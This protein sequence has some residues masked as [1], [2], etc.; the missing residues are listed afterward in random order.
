MV[1]AKITPKKIVKT[2]LISAFTL[3]T[4]FM[5]RDVI[6]SLI[7]T[8]VPMGERMFYKLLAAI[9]ATILLILAIIIITKTDTEIDFI[10]KKISKKNN[11]KKRK[12]K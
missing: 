5:W 7:E 3:A 10:V 12:K 11:K 4:G 1:K 8:I 2:S 9:V 6:N